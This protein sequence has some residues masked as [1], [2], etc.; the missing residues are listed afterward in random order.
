VLADPPKPG[1][2]AVT[3]PAPVEPPPAALKPEDYT[4]PEA[5]AQA[6]FTRD[7]P[8][9][10]T[11]LTTAAELGI[12]QDKMVAMLEKVSPQIQDQMLSPYRAWKGLQEGWAAEIQKDTTY[13]GAKLP[14]TI[15]TIQRGITAFATKPGMSP[16]EVTKA[17]ADVNDALRITGAGNHPALIRLM[18]NAFGK[19]SEGNPVL[20][21][22]SGA[23]KMNA[24]A[25]LY[26]HPTSQPK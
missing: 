1:D 14:E 9:T 25:T 26:N 3:P 22:A 10:A 16:A 2:P 4:I 23:P 7:D 24:A 5:L 15:A 20:G 19:L 12:P 21:N 8:M 17:V 18:A 11:Y 13:G 6:G